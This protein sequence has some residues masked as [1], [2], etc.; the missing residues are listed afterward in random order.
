MAV[1]KR[2]TPLFVPFFLTHAPVSQKNMSTTPRK[3]CASTVNQPVCAFNSL[4]SVSSRRNLFQR[5]L[6]GTWDKKWDHFFHLAAD[7]HSFWLIALNIFRGSDAECLSPVFLRTGIILKNVRQWRSSLEDLI[8]NLIYT[9]HYELSIAQINIDKWYGMYMYVWFY[10]NYLSCCILF[11][12][13]LSLCITLDHF[14][15]F[16]RLLYITYHHLS[17]FFRGK[18]QAKIQ[19]LPMSGAA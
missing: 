3:E 13:F 1:L 9:L 2:W 18:S 6:R 15:S 16:C 14:R 5:L 19:R 12:N 8:G 7:W 4:P 11:H 10:C 17:A